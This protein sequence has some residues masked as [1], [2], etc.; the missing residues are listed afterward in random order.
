MIGENESLEEYFKRVHSMCGYVCYDD[1]NGGDPRDLD[2]LS[3]SMGHWLW[4][5][6][7]LFPKRLQ[8]WREGRMSLFELIEL[9]PEKI[10]QEIAETEKDIE[11]ACKLLGIPFPP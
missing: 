4:A 5:F 9:T 6:Y 7:N 10:T 2:K 1:S 11:K 3:E 8:D